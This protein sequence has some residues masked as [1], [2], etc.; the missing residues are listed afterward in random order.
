M[1]FIV[2]SLGLIFGGMHGVSGH[3]YE[4][5]VV[6]VKPTSAAV[7]AEISVT[8]EQTHCSSV[9]CGI[10]CEQMKRCLSFSVTQH[11]GWLCQCLLYDM[12][13]LNSLYYTY[14]SQTSYY[15]E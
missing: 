14:S 10:Y 1:T 15:G 6:N 13:V 8:F 9:Q 11:D 4:A 2:M 12:L 5:L 3:I 7:L